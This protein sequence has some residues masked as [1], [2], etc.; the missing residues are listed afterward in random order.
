MHILIF[1]VQQQTFVQIIIQFDN[2]I[3]SNTMSSNGCCWFQCIYKTVT[4]EHV[5]VAN[6]D[7][8]GNGIIEGSLTVNNTLN[9]C[10][11][12]NIETLNSSD[13][14]NL[15]STSAIGNMTMLSS[16]DSL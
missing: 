6:L 8:T 9:I 2:L 11:N 5:N 13:I 7:V 16:L 10:P 12:L 14:T 3:S 4:T 1:S 15:T